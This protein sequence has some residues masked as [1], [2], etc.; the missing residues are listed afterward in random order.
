[1]QVS[2]TSFFGLF[3]FF[4]YVGLCFFLVVDLHM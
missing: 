1:M 2:V 3:A 4:F